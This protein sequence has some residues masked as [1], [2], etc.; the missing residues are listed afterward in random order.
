MFVMRI[1][2]VG[3]LVADEERKKEREGDRG[4]K[5]MRKCVCMWN[6]KN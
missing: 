5:C 3:V 6:C 1:D 2:A 4:T